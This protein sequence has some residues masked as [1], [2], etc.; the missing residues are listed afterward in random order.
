MQV[1]R[2]YFVLLFIDG[3][4]FCCN[5][6]GKSIKEYVELFVLRY[7]FSEYCWFC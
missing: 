4:L 6:F 5:V 2:K 3:F 7:L 1:G